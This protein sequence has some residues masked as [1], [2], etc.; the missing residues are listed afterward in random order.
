M[1]SIRKAQ[2]RL[3]AA[4]YS[5]GT[6]RCASDRAPDQLHEE[7][8]FGVMEGIGTPDYS[9]GAPNQLNKVLVSKDREGT[10]K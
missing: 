7:H 4:L 6:V 1:N 8:I 5:T 9:S 10:N 3:S 2:I